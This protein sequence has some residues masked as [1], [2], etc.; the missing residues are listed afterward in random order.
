MLGLQKAVLYAQTQ[1]WSLTSG[2]TLELTPT[3]SA[4]R[5]AEFC[6]YT[7]DLSWGEMVQLSVKSIDIPQHTADLVE[8]ILAGEWHISRNEDE[9]YVITFTFRDLNNGALYRFFNGMWNAGKYKFPKEC[10]FSCRIGLLESK[11]DSTAKPKLIFGAEEMFITSISQIQLSHENNEIIE[12]SVEFKTNTPMFD[13]AGP[14]DFAFSRYW[15][16]AEDSKQSSSGGALSKLVNYGL[17]TANSAIDDFK[18]NLTKEWGKS[19]AKWDF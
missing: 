12:F 2:F 4:T 6:G 19:V 18:N 16:N 5:V 15:S 7:A 11:T 17:N 3:D 14:T 10:A 9:I 1:N 8:K 13:E